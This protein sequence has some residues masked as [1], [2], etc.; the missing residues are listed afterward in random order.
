MGDWI[1]LTFGDARPG[2]VPDVFRF[3]LVSF[4]RVEMI[5][6]DTG[7]APYELESVAPGTSPGPWQPGR[8]YRRAGVTPGALVRYDVAPPSTVR[9]RP[10]PAETTERPP[11]VIGR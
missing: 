8:V 7:Q 10:P 11:A 1:E 6:V 2:A 3:R 5:Y 4:D 9:T